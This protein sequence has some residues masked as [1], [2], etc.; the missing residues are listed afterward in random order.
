MVLHDS[1]RLGEL[2][3]DREQVGQRGREQQRVDPVEQA[4]VAGQDPPGVIGLV[5]ALEDR[6]RQVAVDGGAGQRRGHD[7][8]LEPGDVVHP[9]DL[10]HDGDDQRGSD[11]SGQAFVGLLGADLGGHLA[12]AEAAAHD[13]GSGVGEP[14]HR[15]RE[16][17]PDEPVVHA[18]Q[19]GQRHDRQRDVDDTGDHVRDHQLTVV[20]LGLGGER[21]HDGDDRQHEQ[22]QQ[23]SL[24]PDEER[25]D[26]AVWV[27]LQQQRECH[28]EADDHLNS[29]NVPALFP[30]GHA[31]ELIRTDDDRR[32]AE[33]L[34]TLEP[35]CDQDREYQGESDDGCEPP[36]GVVGHRNLPLMRRTVIVFEHTHTVLVPTQLIEKAVFVQ[37]FLTES[38]YIHSSTG[39]CL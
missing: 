18:A 19:Q 30:V 27:V 9:E 20:V 1:P 11:A 34:N 13:V 12:L 39:F 15:E 17:H 38:R 37:Y 8:H 25:D 36:L 32:H 3:D 23:E 10:E 29:A 16:E 5:G 22:S 24:P 33:D 31:S 21:E 7:H 35:T 4:A 26:R 28:A 2:E 14:G 6:H